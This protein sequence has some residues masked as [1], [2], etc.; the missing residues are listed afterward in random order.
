MFVIAVI[1]ESCFRGGTR[2]YFT[3][4]FFGKDFLVKLVF[5]GFC[6]R[7]R[8]MH[9]LLFLLLLSVQTLPLSSQQTRTSLLATACFLSLREKIELVI[10]RF[11]LMATQGLGMNLDLPQCMK[12]RCSV[13]QRSYGLSM[14]G[15]DFP[16][17]S[18]L[19]EGRCCLIEGEADSGSSLSPF[20]I[21]RSEYLMHFASTRCF[22]FF[23]YSY[24]AT[25]PT[26]KLIAGLVLYESFR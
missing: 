13:P 22:S 16:F 19:L 4:I 10:A 11:P 14:G 9:G 2:Q 15:S 6:S 8:P 12:L 1:I 25:T 18:P 20:R 7:Y 3:R 17:F 23:S 5:G 24:C 26:W 21:P